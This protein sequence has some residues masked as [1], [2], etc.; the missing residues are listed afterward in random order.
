VSDQNEEVRQSAAAGLGEIGDLRA[1]AQ[2]ERLAEKDPSADVRAAAAQAI[3][4]INARELP[5]K[6]PEKTSK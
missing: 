3:E 5:H 4:R 1:V 2:L 6:K